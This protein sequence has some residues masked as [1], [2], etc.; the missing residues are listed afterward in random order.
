MSENNRFQFRVYDKLLKKYGLRRIHTERKFYH[1]IE[2]TEL[3]TLP[4]DTNRFVIEQS[5]GKFSKEN[6]L[7]FENDVLMKIDPDGEK[8]FAVV[9]WFQGNMVLHEIHGTVL[10]WDGTRYSILG[11]I[12]DTSSILEKFKDFS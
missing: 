8:H 4:I 11:N 1:C 12:H 6:E 9:G 7:I 2:I 10:V 5:S 3:I